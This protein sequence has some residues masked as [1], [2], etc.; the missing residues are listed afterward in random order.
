L[1]FLVWRDVLPA[2]DESTTLV[3]RQPVTT[4]QLAIN[5]VPCDDTFDIEDGTSTQLTLDTLSLDTE[6]V[7][8]IRDLVDGTWQ[9]FRPAL[10]SETLAHVPQRPTLV[11]RKGTSVAIA[12]EHRRLLQERQYLYMV[13]IALLETVIDGSR[14][15]KGGRQRSEPGPF[16]T[17]GFT[18]AMEFRLDLP[19][20]IHCCVFRIRAAKTNLTVDGT[21]MYVVGFVPGRPQPSPGPV[22]VDNPHLYRWSGVSPH[23]HFRTPSVPDHPTGIHVRN[24]TH[25][26]ALIR[27]QQPANSAEHVNLVYSVFLNNSYVDKFTCVGETQDCQLQLNDLVPNTHYRVAVTAESTMGRSQNNNTLHFSTRGVPLPGELAKQARPLTSTLP[28]R[29]VL[30]PPA[31]FVKLVAKEKGRGNATGEVG[32]M[33]TDDAGSTILAMNSRDA[34]ATAPGSRKSPERQTSPSRRLAATDPR[35]RSS[36]KRQ[37]PPLPSDLKKR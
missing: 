8:S 7:I 14:S 31:A 12:W 1:D 17:L 22:V 26:S 11:E 5:D 19:Y 29:T 13:E 27:W 32:D 24:L 18:T 2:V 28:P 6:Y 25:N 16:Q 33:L 21:P 35:L 37:L 23:A 20:P 3:W 15:G 30:R 4:H 34:A 9:E 10:T 36:A